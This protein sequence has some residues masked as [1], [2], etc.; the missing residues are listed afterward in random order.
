MKNKV[1]LT[2]SSF[3]LT[4]VMFCLISFTGVTQV[5]A[6]SEQA[7]VEAIVE[8]LV[9]DGKLPE[10]HL[11]YKDYYTYQIIFLKYYE[12]S[13]ESYLEYFA[14][15]T[16]ERMQTLYGWYNDDNEEWMD[17]LTKLSIPVSSVKANKTIGM[18]FDGQFTWLIWTSEYIP[19]EL[20]NL[21]S[22]TIEENGK[23]VTYSN[24][25]I[26]GGCEHIN[27]DGFF[28]ATFSVY[29]PEKNLQ[30]NK[31]P[32]AGFHECGSGVYSYGVEVEGKS[33]FIIKGWEAELDHLWGGEE[34]DPEGVYDFKST[35]EIT[36]DLKE[37]IKYEGNPVT[38]LS[39]MVYVV[40]T[41]CEA[42]SVYDLGFGGYKHYVYFNTSIDLEAVYRVD[43]GYT[44]L[45][46]D[47]IWAAQLFDE[48]KTRT[49]KKSLSEDKD[50][51]GIFNL[52]NYQGLTVGNFSSNE[53]NAKTYKYRLMLNYNEDNWELDELV[54][55]TESNYKRIDEFQIFRLNFVH[56]GKEYDQEIQMDTVSGETKKIYNRDL[57]L[58]TTTP[59]W[60]F[61]ETAGNVGDAV[62]DIAGDIADGVGDVVGGIGD[63]ISGAVDN[64]PKVGKALLIT[65]GV[66]LGGIG[67]FYLFKLI[68]M[69][70]QVF[71]KKE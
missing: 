63:T 10:W 25:E 58:D 3:V 57:V 40:I 70:S 44:L 59:I 20:L 5:H 48:P 60:K 66:V 69:I 16:E 49:L 41:D 29:F 56:N 45:A 71:K 28:E 24:K 11:K 46:D 31:T 33:E 7:R 61:K 37:K 67:L 32:I 26:T 22:V 2:I 14:S 13:D 65:G 68:L 55:I 8:E 27:G 19:Y 53:K 39:T 9:E 21:K 38:Q 36:F 51:G 50:R 64:A 15:I 34:I 54:N 1:W 47:V 42:Q 62:G 43:V 23:D 18:M 6:Y 30:F 17:L 12:S 35:N 52:F 4:L